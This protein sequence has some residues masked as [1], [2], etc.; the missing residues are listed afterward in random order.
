MGVDFLIHRYAREKPVNEMQ[1]ANHSK[2]PKSSLDWSCKA[3]IGALLLSILACSP[4]VE[5]PPGIQV[6]EAPVQQEINEG[7]L[8]EID[9]AVLAA[10]ASY[11]IRG[12]LLSKRRYRFDQ[13]ARIAPWDFAIG[14]GPM[15]D[16][17]V[18][19]G[20]AVTQGDRFLFWKRFATGLPLRDIE[21]HSANL[22][23]IPADTAVADQLESIRDGSLLELTGT[24]VDVKLT[25]GLLI[26][27]SLTR[28]DR[29]AGAC[30][31]LLVRE[32]TPLPGA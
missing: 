11:R 16:E 3:G 19:S 25:D 6:K 15:S 26:P 27:T 4:R 23:L 24:L 13:L 22:H 18:I 5:L 20:I 21:R 10:R 31:I 32:F 30:E 12:K 8:I 17:A 9:G 7:E 29:G 1:I 28:D 14:W 2:H